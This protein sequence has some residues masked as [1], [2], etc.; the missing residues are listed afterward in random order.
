MELA[1]PLFPPKQIAL[2]DEVE[3]EIEVVFVI[4]TEAVFV[5]PFASVTVSE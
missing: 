4:V 5:Q 1:V 2:E 3:T